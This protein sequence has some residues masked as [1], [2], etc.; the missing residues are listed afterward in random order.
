MSIQHHLNQKSV[1]R[2]TS[3]KFILSIV[4][5]LSAGRSG[6]KIKNLKSLGSRF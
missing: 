4:E 2:L 6:T 3:T 5:G 1:L